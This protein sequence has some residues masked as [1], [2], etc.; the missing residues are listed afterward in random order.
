MQQP[1][2]TKPHLVLPSPPLPAMLTAKALITASPGSWSPE[3]QGLWMSPGRLLQLV[4]VLRRRLMQP[5]RPASLFSTHH[6]RMGRS[7]LTHFYPLLFHGESKSSAGEVFLNSLT[8]L[9]PQLIPAEVQGLPV[10]APYAASVVL[11]SSLS[12]RHRES[13]LLSPFPGQCSVHRR[14]LFFLLRHWQ[15]ET[16]R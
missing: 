14:F 1:P 7:F 12:E 3:F 2:L 13:P 9:S 8:G 6:R 4:S 5:A 10:S 11:N 15:R 16:R